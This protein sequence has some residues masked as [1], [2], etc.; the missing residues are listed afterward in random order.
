MVEIFI[1]FLKR[2]LVLLPGILAAFLVAKGVY[3]I[4]DRKIPAELAL[5]IAYAFTAYVLIPAFIRLVRFFFRPK[6]IPHYCITPDG[7]ASDPIN[8]GVIGSSKQLIRA[9]TKAGWYVADK[10]TI[11]NVLKLI[12]SVIFKQ[13]YPNAPFSNLYLFGRRQDIGFELP[14]DDNPS[15]RH[16]VRFWLSEP[17]LTK[18]EEEHLQFWQRHG[19]NKVKVQKTSKFWVGAASKDTGIN[20]IRHTAQITHMIHPNTNAERDLIIKG[21]KKTGMVVKTQKITINKPYKLRNR[22]W[23][24]YLHSDGKMTI[25][26]LKG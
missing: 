6:H 15:H 5:L 11:R 23:R 18:Q 25:A 22:V 4:L 3:P 26:T 9:M 21:L 2:S 16:H 20:L 17:L 19:P 14:L 1:R 7:F 13:P 24:G 8:V 12:M 10:R